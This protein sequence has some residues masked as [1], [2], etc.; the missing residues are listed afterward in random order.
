MPATWLVALKTVLPY[1]DTVA[2]VALPLFTRKKAESEA[3]QIE[4]LQ[5]QVSELQAASLQNAEH[6]KDIAGQ[7][8]VLVAA[9]AEGGKRAELAQ[10]SVLR[11]AILAIVVAAVA[12]AGVIVLAT[13]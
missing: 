6:L 12:L 4:L 1:L 5:K 10:R 7:L 11:L 8:E 3:N 13:K 2:N 9:I